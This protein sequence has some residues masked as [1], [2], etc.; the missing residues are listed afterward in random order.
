MSSKTND[1]TEPQHNP[2]TT[3]DG[4]QLLRLKIILPFRQPF[5]AGIKSLVKDHCLERK[6]IRR[7][8]IIGRKKGGKTIKLSQC[9]HHSTSGFAY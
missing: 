4:K 7:S 2:S 8:K 3:Y 1:K 6:N 9:F 5:L